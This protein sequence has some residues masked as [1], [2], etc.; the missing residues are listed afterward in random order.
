MKAKKI[1]IG[2]E[3][4]YLSDDRAMVHRRTVAGFQY[5]VDDKVVGVKMVDHWRPISPYMVLGQAIELTEDSP[6]EEV[7]V[8]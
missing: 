8:E 1:S 5:S 4:F 2:N 3:V 6:K 7:P